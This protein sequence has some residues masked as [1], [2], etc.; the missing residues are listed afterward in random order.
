MNVLIVVLN[1]PAATFNVFQL[2]EMERAGTCGDA[3]NAGKR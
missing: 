2:P 3:I 1:F